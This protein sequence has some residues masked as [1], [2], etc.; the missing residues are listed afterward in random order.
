MLD[1]VFDEPYVV[2]VF[3]RQMFCNNIFGPGLSFVDLTAH[4]YLLLIMSPLNNLNWS[5][6]C[7]IVVKLAPSYFLGP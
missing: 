3:L 4:L 5:I 7:E 2:F 1:L 6:Y